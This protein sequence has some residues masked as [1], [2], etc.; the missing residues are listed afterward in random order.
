MKKLTIKNAPQVFS[1]LEDFL[2]ENP[3]AAETVLKAINDALNALNNQDVFGTEG[4]L[5]PRGSQR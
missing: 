3:E 5:D 1:R 2:I 4:Q